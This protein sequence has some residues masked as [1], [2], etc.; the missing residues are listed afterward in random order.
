MLNSV[1]V[2]D[3]EILDLVKRF[4]KLA[5]N[6]WIQIDTKLHNFGQKKA[7]N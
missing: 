4:F 3:D 5:V 6:F 7:A 1:S 2:I